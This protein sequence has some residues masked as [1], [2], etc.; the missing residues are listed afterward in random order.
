MKFLRTIRFIVDSLSLFPQNPPQVAIKLLTE[1]HYMRLNKSIRT[2]RVGLAAAMLSA[3]GAMLAPNADAAALQGQL[4]VRPLTPQEKK[5]YVLPTAQ[6]ASGLSTVGIGQPAYIDALINRTIAQSNIIGVTWTIT[7]QPVGSTATL[8]TSPL[9]ATI[10]PYKM[11]DRVAYQVAG[12]TVLLPDVTGIYTVSALIQTA[13][14]GQTNVSQTITAGTYMGLNTCALCHS[15]GLIAPNKVAPWSQTAHATFLTRAI[16]GAESDHYGKNCIS[17]HTLG[18][19]VNT[20]SINGGFDDVATTLGWT[21]PTVLTNGNWAAMPAALK[22]LSNIQCENCHG[23]GSQHAFGLGDKTKISVSYAAGDCAQCHDSKPNH[24][25]S[26]EWNNSRHAIATRTPSGPSRIHCVRCHTAGGFNGYIENASVN[27]GKTNTYTTNTVYEA[28]S[29]AACHDPH[30]AKNPHQLRAGTNYVW[31]AGETIVGLGSSALCYECHHARNNAGEQNIA[32]FAL[33]KP[34]WGGGS[35]FGVHDSPQ[36]DMIEGKNA[37]NYG[38]DIPSGSHRKA[39]EG[40]CVGCHM[41]PVATTDPDYGKVGGHTF[42]MSYTTIVGGVTNVH[43]KVDVCVKCHGEIEDFNLVRKDYN[44]DGTIEGVQAEVQGLLSKLST[45][46]PNSTYR[47][48]GNYVADGLVKTSASAKTN[49]PVKFLKAGFNLGFVT[50]DASKGIHNTPYA[51]GLLKASI[52]DLTG[53]ANQDGIPD[54]WQIQYFGSA[55]SASAAPNANPSGDGVPN[56]LKFGLGIDPTVKGVVLPDG[57]VWAN[58][59]KVG[60]NAATNIVQIYKAAEVV[61]NTEVGKT[62]QLQAI[63]S[64]DGGW[65][66]IGSPVAG[67]GNAVSLVTPT[68]VNGQQFY[69]VQITP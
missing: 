62:Y 4:S 14:S 43:D 56:W 36:A 34:T 66:N 25:R 22:N 29:C 64:L 5:D 19:D 58:A 20:N 38:K 32:N 60:G 65:K 3:I 48:D 61:Y 21:F 1:N 23:P 2:V 41:Q 35:S 15:G 67:T 9:G 18:Y 45:L 8:S 33:G 59:G 10:P 54:S 42:G 11:A 31:A 57:V 30:D 13:D 27:A 24:I 17:C 37:I 47:A 40:V 50:A 53:D 7:S 46:L 69:R 44:G 6:G 52:A 39:V 49:W 12:R 51:V 63:S 28:I 16:D 55:T 26:A 68:R